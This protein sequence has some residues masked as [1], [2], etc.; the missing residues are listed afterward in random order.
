MCQVLMKLESELWVFWHM[1]Q[2]YRGMNSQDTW[3]QKGDRN[4]E[5]RS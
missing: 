3:A 2:N 1:I 4:M 5:W